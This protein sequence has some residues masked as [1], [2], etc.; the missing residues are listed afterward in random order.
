MIKRY[1]GAP[2]KAGGGS[3][4]SSSVQ[5]IRPSQ[6]PQRQLMLLWLRET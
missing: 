3:G 4:G 1:K 6:R 5:T 2:P